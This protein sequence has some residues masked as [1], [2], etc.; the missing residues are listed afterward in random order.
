ML[1][2]VNS[3]LQPQCQVKI[4]VPW[5]QRLETIRWAGQ[6]HT[7]A[8]TNPSVIQHHQNS[9]LSSVALFILTFILQSLK[10]STSYFI[11]CHYSLLYQLNHSH[12][13]MALNCI[14]SRPEFIMGTCLH[15]QLKYYVQIIR[16]YTSKYRC[17]CT[18]NTYK[19]HCWNHFMPQTT[20]EIL[21]IQCIYLPAPPSTDP[22]LTHAF[23]KKSRDLRKNKKPHNTS[24]WW[25]AMNWL[26]AWKLENQSQNTWKVQWKMVWEMERRRWNESAKYGTRYTVRET[27]LIYI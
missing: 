2:G 4:L 18:Q 8:L 9:I 11:S 23:R 17:K 19:S 25:S 14:F 16:L 26:H 5:P 15:L 3:Y 1:N 7:H 6:S 22:W 27:E 12:S 20:T 10:C 21:F 24:E 13:K